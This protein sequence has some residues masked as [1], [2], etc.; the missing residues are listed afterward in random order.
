MNA[1]EPQVAWTAIGEGAEVIDRNGEQAGKVSRTVGDT[2]AD[3]FTGLAV[4]VK[5]LGKEHLVES[6]RVTGIWPDRVQ[7]DL[8][9][10]EIEALPE[11]EDAPV[12]RWRPE[13]PGFFARLFGRR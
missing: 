13:E 7:V 11:Y 9:A 6:E 2:D 1:E 10:D 3:V 8:T 12:E 5:S 4:R